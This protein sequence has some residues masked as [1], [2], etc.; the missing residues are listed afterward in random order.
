MKTDA[1]ITQKKKN[2]GA[3]FDRISG[4]YDFLNHFL[5][6]GID[7]YWR[8]KAIAGMP[9]QKE[10]LDVAIGTA[11]LTLEMF[12]Q[13]KAQKVV[14]IDLSEQMM[15]I[16]EKKLQQ[17]GFSATFLPANAQDMP[18]STNRFD[19]VTCAYGC[20]NFSNLQ[21]GLSEMY[22]V[23]Q[24]G[25]M[26]LILEFSYPTNPLIRWLYDLYFSC[27]L[28]CLGRCISRDK[29]AYTYL[30]RSVK[31]FCYGE[32]FVQQLREVGFTDIQYEP[33]TWGITTIYRATKP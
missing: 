32:T 22:R 8:K 12:R 11:D 20:R 25:G 4:T 2:I 6:L 29:D 1:L 15:A 5:S 30:N 14:G 24:S 33:L 27:V 19:A 7:R 13:H 10:V 31:D 21:E 18:F 17:H 16:G 26:L 9:P 3:L 28:P 23:L